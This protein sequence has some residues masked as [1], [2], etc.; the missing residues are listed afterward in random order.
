MGGA[1]VERAGPGVDAGRDPVPSAAARDVPRAEDR[2]VV[3]VNGL[4]AKTGGGAT[5]LRNVCPLLARAAGVELHMCLHRDQDA[6]GL[7]GDPDIRLHRL[8][9]ATGFWRLLAREQVAVPRLARRLHAD[10]VFS[11]ANYGPLAAPASVVMLRNALAVGAVDK[12]LVKRAYWGLLAVA[13]AASLARCRRAIAVSAYAADA[14]A[15]GRL[16]RYRGRV[17][18]VPHGVG[19][20]FGPGDGA[21]R[22]PFVLAVSDLYVQKNLEALVRAFG[23]VR[24]SRPDLELRIAGRPVDA[25]YARGLA[26]LAAAAAPGAVAFL[27]HVPAEG[28]ADLYRRCAAFAFPSRVETFGNPLLEAMACGAPIACSNAAALPEVAGDAALSVDPDDEV[29]LAAALGRLL[30][31]PVLARELGQRALSRAAGFTWQRTAE[32]T[33]AVLRDAAGRS[34]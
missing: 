19:A 4:H 8:D 26:R 11:P 20:P 25:E 22:E 18:V 14:L 30:D 10:V 1:T 27:G 21:P 33:L 32:A 31:D 9:F 12:R 5:Y 6:L 28:L 24:A 29:A 3:L 2:L 13:T 15:G 17:A 7:D 34:G 23:I 16:A